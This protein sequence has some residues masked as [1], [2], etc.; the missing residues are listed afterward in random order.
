MEK[1]LVCGAGGF[2]GHHLVRFLKQK[3]YWVR[4]ADIKLPEFSSSEEADEFLKIDL[5]EMKNCLEATKGIDKV[6]QLAADMGGMQ[7]IS[8]VHADI[9]RNSALINLNIAEACRVNKIKR[10]FF[11]SSA[12]VYPEER[13][14]TPE[15]QPLQE[16][17]AYPAHPDTAYGWEKIFS[18]NLYES[19]EQDYGLEVRIARYHN[20]FGPEG[21]FEGGKEKAP[22]NMCM[23]VAKA[24]DGDNITLFSDGKQTRSFCHID[25]CLE[26][27]YKLMESD[28]REPLNIGS[29]QLVSMNEMANM[30][31]DISGKKL[32]IIYDQTKAQGVRGR[33]SDNTLFRQKFNWAPSMKL[34][35]GLKTT[36]AWINKQVNK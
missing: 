19:Y 17:D 10:V 25:E 13:Q 32:N 29:D 23:Q 21:T 1:I 11:S 3:G 12:C 18:E 24:K 36:Y 33:N 31:I 5:R 8:N 16:S 7:Y 35:D 27:T 6:Y 26:A 4:G 22:A 15:V 20:I 28:V 14:L 9:M 34:E 2:I 30:I